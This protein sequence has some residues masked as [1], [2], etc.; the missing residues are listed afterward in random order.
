MYIYLSKRGHNLVILTGGNEIVCWK[1]Q[2]VIFSFPV[3]LIPPTS[4]RQM[5]FAGDVYVWVE[6]RQTTS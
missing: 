5:D 3:A 6:W 2:L 4:V 1:G